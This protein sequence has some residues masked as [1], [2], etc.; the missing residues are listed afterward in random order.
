MTEQADRPDREV[1]IWPAGEPERRSG[2]DHYRAVRF[3]IAPGV[4]S[5][6]SS[7]AIR[8]T[9]RMATHNVDGS[10]DEVAAVVTHDSP[11][12]TF[13]TIYFGRTVAQ[14][15]EFQPFFRTASSMRHMIELALREVAPEGTLGFE[16]LEQRPEPPVEA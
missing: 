7:D 2:E 11:D 10:G 16:Y 9:T 3:R 15:Q 4:G 1:T 13:G 5:V 12:S 8:G 14:T 6:A